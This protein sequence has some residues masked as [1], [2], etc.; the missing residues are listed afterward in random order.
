MAA[1]AE[2]MVDRGTTFNAT[3]VITN[4]A[5]GESLNISGY[6]FA[7]QIRKSY[8][9]ANATANI[10]CSINSAANGNLAL[11]MANSVTAG[12]APGRYVYDIRMT[13]T[14]NVVTRVVE[15]IITIT[16]NATY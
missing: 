14:A 3:I 11:A 15:G 8:Y 2:L 4:N 9:S 7:S 5:T 6:S 13:D 12:I 16:P 10:T 1:Y